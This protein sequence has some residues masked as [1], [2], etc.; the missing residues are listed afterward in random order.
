[1]TGPSGSGKSTVVAALL[2]W[3]EPTAGTMLADG[4]DVHAL[5]GDEL[6]RG[7]AWCGPWTQVF[8]SSL[9][10]NLLLAAPD[11]GDEQLVA[12]L[13]RAQLGDWFAGLPEGLDTP[14]GEHG[15]AVSG[16]ER[17]R[18]G[19]RGF[20]W[21]NGRS[22]SWMNPPHIWIPRRPLPWPPRFWRSRSGVR[23]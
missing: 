3:L 23:R 14:I 6:H 16:G 4:R 20:C 22:W 10:A 7:V 1:M 2:R 18:I 11:S 8:D 19:W 15:G 13:R 9:R 21:P 12:A 17:Q 5:T